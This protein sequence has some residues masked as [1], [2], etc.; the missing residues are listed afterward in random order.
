M[1]RTYT[2]TR[3]ACYIGYFVQAIINCL[4]PVLFIVYQTELS[5]SYSQLSTLVLVNFLTQLGVDL[6][7]ARY[8]DRIGYRRAVTLAHV[9]AASGLILLSVLPRQMANPFVGL[10]IPTVIYA[11]GSGLI[12]VL[13]SPIV[14]SLPSDSKSAGMSLLHSFYCWGQLAVVLVTTLLLRVIGAEHWVFIPLVWAVVPLLNLFNFLTVPLVPPV[15]AEEK[16]PVRQLLHSGFFAAA[17]L[18]MLAAGAAEQAMSQW[19]S[20]FAETSLHVSKVVGD[21]LGPCL[22]AALMGAAR[23]FYGLVGAKIR[24]RNALTASAGLCVAAYLLAALAPWP[25]VSLLGCGLCG[26]SVGL[27]WPGVFSLTS[28]RFSAGG[29][30]MFALLAVFGDLGCA[31]GPWLTG[32]VSAAAESAGGALSGLSCGLLAALVFPVLMLILLQIQKRSER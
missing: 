27:M 8:V 17:L 12:E 32:E 13:I 5:L 7:S 18:L 25:L 1:K 28:A 20:L 21:I 30:T 11:F 3:V 31:F 4:S 10:L 19:A 2:G 9:L 22:F 26:L 24:L 14:D 16:V 6:L 23:L 15:S 29:T